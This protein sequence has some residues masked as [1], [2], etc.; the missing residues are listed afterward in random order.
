[1][2]GTP[3]LNR[4]G[5]QQQLSFLFFLLLKLH[6]SPMIDRWSQPKLPCFIDWHCA[7]RDRYCVIFIC[8]DMGGLSKPLRSSNP[9]LFCF[10]K[11]YKTQW[12]SKGGLKQQQQQLNS[13]THVIPLVIGRC[14][15]IRLIVMRPDRSRIS[16]QTLW[17][18]RLA[19]SQKFLSSSS[20]RIS[21]PRKRVSNRI[22]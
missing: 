22:D 21:N 12:N 8:M 13:S 6:L 9:L 19:Q 1:V 4:I 11:M 2:N 20:I 17:P 16:A 5:Q 7:E 14:R 10:W 3:A 18:C 15:I